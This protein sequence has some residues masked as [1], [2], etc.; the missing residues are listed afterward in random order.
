MQTFNIDNN[1]FTKE[2]CV[3]FYSLI[4]ETLSR[5]FIS[6]EEHDVSTDIKNIFATFPIAINKFH[7]C[8]YL[9]DLLTILDMPNNAQHNI[10]A[11]NYFP[12]LKQKDR[13]IPDISFQP[14]GT[15]LSLQHA[16]AM[17]AVVIYNTL[18]WNTI[19]KRSD[20][21]WPVRSTQEKLTVFQEV[22]RIDKNDVM[23]FLINNEIDN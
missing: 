5:L 15:V 7:L 17:R 1:A 8:T 3:F 2:Q 21:I 6:D 9:F 4:R 10:C 12:E 16:Q 11:K 13:S 23:R 18:L 22:M 19:A 20:Q 14:S